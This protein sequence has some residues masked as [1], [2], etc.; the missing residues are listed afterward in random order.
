MAAMDEKGV[1]KVIKLLLGYK[2]LLGRQVLSYKLA[3][4]GIIIR[5]KA[6]WV[7]KGFEQVK[8]IDFYSTWS[9]VIKSASWRILLALATR[10]GMEVEYLDVDIAYLE[11]LFDEEVWVE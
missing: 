6:R 8:D 2:V 5:Y 10:Y 4:D 11:V 1:Q 7:A 9:S 3:P